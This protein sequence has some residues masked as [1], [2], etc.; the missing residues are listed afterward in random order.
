MIVKLLVEGGN[1]TPG[2]AIAQQLGPMGINMGKVISEVN[3]ATQEFKGM[4]VPVHLDVDGKTKDFTIKVM[5]PPTSELIKKELGVEK[6]SG[7]R[8]K[9]II[10]NLAIEQIVSITKTKQQYM[11]A[12]EF[13]SA[14]KS[15]IGTCLA[16]GV[17]IESKDPKEILEAIEDGEYKKEI[18]QQKTEV[19]PEKRKELDDYFVEINTQ[20]E[21]VKKKEE[22]EKKV[23]EEKKAEASVSA[24]GAEKPVEEKK[25]PAKK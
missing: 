7:E 22:E 12:K 14:L 3:K 18:E 6:G 13:I 20:Q 11:L 4:N 8:L 2:P 15:V 19:S 16:M 23:E 10:G 25:A 24:P 9:I 5:S 1:M 17:L 21:A